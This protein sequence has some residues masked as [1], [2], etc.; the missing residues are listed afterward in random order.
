MPFNTGEACS[1]E[2]VPT[3]FD[4]APSTRIGARLLTGVAATSLALVKRDALRLLESGYRWGSRRSIRQKRHHAVR[5]VARHVDLP[6]RVDRHAD[7][8]PIPVHDRRSGLLSVGCVRRQSEIAVRDIDFAVSIY[9]HADRVEQSG[10]DRRACPLPVRPIGCHGAAVANAAAT[11][12]DV[13]V[14]IA[15]ERY[16]ERV[17][18]GD[19]RRR[20]PRSVR[21]IRRNGTG[22]AAA[23]AVQDVDFAVLVDRYALRLIDRSTDRRARRRSVGLVARYR[24]IAVRDVD[25]AVRIH[26]HAVRVVQPGG[27]RRSGLRSIRLVRRQRVVAEFTT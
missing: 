17:G 5:V 25:L 11:I 4:H 21:Q 16:A 23:V 19:D 6:G 8:S 22:P 13:D 15:V 1:C 10:G 7:G 18:S 2:Q 24:V 14:P 9:R 12:G 27:D 20:C 26:R 3:R